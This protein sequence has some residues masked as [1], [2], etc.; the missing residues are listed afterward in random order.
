MQ[1]SIVNYQ[2][3]LREERFDSEYHKPKYIQLDKALTS[4][5]FIPLAETKPYIKCG[6]FGSTILSSTY[7]DVGI[8]VARPFNINGM[9][10][11]SGEIVKIP[12]IDVVEKNLKIFRPKDILFSRVG[13]VRCGVIPENFEE[14]TLSPNVI[15]LRIKSDD[16]NPYYLTVFF[17]SKYGFPQIE[18]GLKVVAQPTIS[19]ELIKNLKVVLLSKNFQ[20]LIEKLFLLSI[21]SRHDSKLLY[22]Q[23]EQLL[24]SELGL[25]DWQPQYQST[26]VKNYS[27]TQGAERIDADCFLPKYD[28][29]ISK[30]TKYGKT[31][32]LVDNFKITK[33]KGISYDELGKTGVIKTKQ[34]KKD[35]INFDVESYSIVD[36]Y[37]VEDKDVLFASM[38][39]GSL[40]KTNIFYE[41]ESG[42]K[43][44]TDSTIRVLRKKI[45]SQFKP[46]VLKVFMSSWVGQELIYQNIIGSSGIISLND[47]YLNKLLLPQLPSD[48]ANKIEN[49]VKDAHINHR[50]SKSLLEIAKLGVEK[51]I[52]ENEE[53]AERWIERELGKLGVTL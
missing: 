48:L 25:A 15:A 43:L 28:H 11:G 49:D 36:T 37:L 8:I 52:E 30:I 26:F 1:F 19:T 21:R 53:V 51:A 42:D 2:A 31:T 6:P 20:C 34:L 16:F 4:K 29:I 10:F 3:A 14:V 45:N 44:T 47:S 24:L 32:R 18:R 12:K 50:N 13:D 5:N 40:G 38:G 7:S 23:A 33:S 22:F 9:M 41:F 27:D 35:F 39:V 17:N 46:E